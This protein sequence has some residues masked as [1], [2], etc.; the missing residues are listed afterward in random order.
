MSAHEHRLFFLL[1]QAA[2]RLKK[3][4]DRSLTSTGGLTV[5]QT[6]VLAIVAK[7]GQMAQKEIADQLQLNESAMTA[8]VARLLKSGH[9]TRTRHPSD[10]RAWQIA[11]TPAG[12]TALANVQEPFSDI[13]AALDT[14]IGKQRT[15]ALARD[16]KAIIEAFN[17]EG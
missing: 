8:M 12:T 10:A 2:H 11:L 16:L 9:I 5:A 1:Q 7:A 17:S 4:A 14:A 3:Q 6:A 15:A 13:N